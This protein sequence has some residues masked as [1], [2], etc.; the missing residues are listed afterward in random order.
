MKNGTLC[1]I[2]TVLAVQAA[3]LSAGSPALTFTDRVEAQ[4]AIEG[5]YWR[6]RLW[7]K[8]NPDPKPALSQVMPDDMLRSKVEDYLKESAALES[9]WGRPVTAEQLQAELD[10]MARVMRKECA[11]RLL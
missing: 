6:L 11:L 1:L 10:R 3:P 4:R 5:V 8:E 9:R 7:P 2:V